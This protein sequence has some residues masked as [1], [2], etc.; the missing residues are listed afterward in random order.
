MCG[1]LGIVARSGGPALPDDAV[2]LR[3]RDL[4]THRGPDGAGFIRYGNL[5]FAHRRLSVIDPSPLGAQPMMNAAGDGVIVYNGELYN[6]VTLR[7]SMSVDFRSHCDTE[8]LVELLSREGASALSRLRGMYAFGFADLKRRTLLLAR[9]PLGIK[10][11]YYSQGDGVIRFA[12]EIPPLLALPDISTQ[13]D[14]VG[15]RAYLSTIRTT[16]GAHTMYRDIKTLLPGE[17]IEFSLDDPTRVIRRGLTPMSSSFGEDARELIAES[18][19]LHLRSDVPMCALL[20]GG[21]DSSIIVREASTQVRRLQTYC[22]GARS[23]DPHAVDDFSVAREVAAF[24]GTEHHEAPV[25]REL[26]VARWGELIS[27]SRVPM[28]TPNEV[29]INEVAR[30]LRSQGHVVALSGE[31]ADELFG[32][33][34]I[35][36][37]AAARIHTVGK[38]PIAHAAAAELQGASW[39]PCGALGG[40]LSEDAAVADGGLDSTLREYI[41]E[42]ER[43]GYARESDPV[44]AHLR[45]QRRINLA[46]L[47]LRLDGATMRASV[48]G[49][50]PFADAIVGSFAEALSLD[51]KFDVRAK[52]GETA[53]ERAARTKLVLRRAY[54]GVLPESV[55]TR[56]KASFPLPFERWLVEENPLRDYVHTHFAREVLNVPLLHAL[57]SDPGTH[58]RVLWPVANLAAWGS[59]L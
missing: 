4:M 11:L 14:F 43:V 36:L 22:S 25:T 2:V 3:A 33:Y 7:E 13:P 42:F 41:N 44:Q 52:D 38:V 48:E 32:G 49:R 18:V 12:S 58:W 51:Q 28:S 31:G 27:A 21:L 5:V 56:P 35:S 39:I 59:K 8:T 34:D 57:L 17:W 40:V 55:I 37:T 6:D 54:A 20:S 10:P 47:L 53:G 29:A 23:G 16:I 50:T 45:V 30:V 24:C 9:D 1:I 19:R 15:V 46:G 26:F